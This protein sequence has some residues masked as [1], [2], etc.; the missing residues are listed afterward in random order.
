[1]SALM[2]AKLPQQ[3]HRDFIIYGERFTAAT[4]APHG[5]VETAP[6]SQVCGH[7]LPAIGEKG[8]R[9]R[10]GCEEEAARRRDGQQEAAAQVLEQTLRRA[11]AIKPR[12][13]TQ[14]L[15]PKP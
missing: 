4:L 14:P 6:A 2:M 1:M 12:A 13:H 10:H 15:N 11:Q 5:V 3:L 7:A 8:A 9:G